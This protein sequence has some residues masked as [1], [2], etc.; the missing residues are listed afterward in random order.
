MDPVAA[1][2]SSKC[3]ASVGFCP[4]FMKP[5]ICV[6][7]EVVLQIGQNW[8]K[9]VWFT[10][11]WIW[12]SRYTACVET[13]AWFC[14]YRALRYWQSDTLICKCSACFWEPIWLFFTSNLRQIFTDNIFTENI[15]VFKIPLFD[16]DSAALIMQRCAVLKIISHKI[17]VTVTVKN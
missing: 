14:H 2:T 6:N 9:P 12:P 3:C 16:T 1:K 11:R 13:L 17:S 7:L 5:G 15:I 10:W 8:G 4:G